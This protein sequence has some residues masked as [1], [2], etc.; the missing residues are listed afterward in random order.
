MFKNTKISFAGFAVL[1][2]TASHAVADQ[3]PSY[4]VTV[5]NITQGQTFTPI[6]V[7]THNPSIALFELGTAASTELEI[8]AE[9]GATGPLV[10]A[11]LL[12]RVVDYGELR[13]LLGDLHYGWMIAAIGVPNR[14]FGRQTRPLR[15]PEQERAI[16]GHAAPDHVGQGRSHRMPGNRVCSGDNQQTGGSLP[17]KRQVH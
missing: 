4:T 13:V 3:R 9:G 15:K 14:I 1:A 11:F 6:L 8:L 16:L 17:E 2:L 5:T 10:L 12:I 7:T